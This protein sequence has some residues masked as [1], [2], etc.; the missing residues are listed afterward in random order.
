ML[1]EIKYIHRNRLYFRIPST[2]TTKSMIRMMNLDFVSSIRDVM[3][4]R[5]RVRK[6][7]R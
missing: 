2:T 3:L 5:I 1:N 6:M 4:S 7:S